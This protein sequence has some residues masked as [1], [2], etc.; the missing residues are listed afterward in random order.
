MARK[1]GD[2]VS[3][4]QGGEKTLKGVISSIDEGI[5]TIAVGNQDLRVKVAYLA[6]YKDEV[7]KERKE[8]PITAEVPKGMQAW[9]TK[10]KA[11]AKAEADAAKKKAS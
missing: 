9:E 4:D 11:R 1:P 2:K 10:V 5:A 6:E 3:W 7:S 8:R